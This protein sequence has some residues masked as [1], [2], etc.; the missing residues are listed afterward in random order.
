MGDEVCSRLQD[1]ERNNS[2]F[3]AEIMPSYQGH[4]NTRN[5]HTAN[6]W[7]CARCCCYFLCVQIVRDNI[8]DSRQMVLIPMLKESASARKDKYIQK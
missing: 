8:Q 6:Y 5:E 4:T 1:A 7:R 3:V 2:C